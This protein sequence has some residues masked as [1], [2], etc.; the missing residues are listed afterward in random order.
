[1]AF[2]RDTFVIQDEYYQRSMIE[3]ISEN[4][5]LFNQGTNNALILDVGGITGDY[6]YETFFPDDASYDDRR[7]ETNVSDYSFKD[8]TQSEEVTVDIARVNGYKKTLSSWYKIAQTPEMLSTIAG[9]YMAR[10]RTRSF[11]RDSLTS[12]DASM[13]SIGSGVILDVTGETTKTMKAE[14]INEACGKFGDMASNLGV[15]I[16]HS[17]IYRDMIGSYITDNIFNIT[18]L[19][20]RA[21]FVPALGRT[22]VVTDNEALY[23]AIGAW[24]SEGTYSIGDK[25]L[26]GTAV[27][28][29]KTGTNTSTS[30]ASDSTNWEAS[31]REYYSYLLSSGAGK[32]SQGKMD[33]IFTDVNIASTN[34]L[35]LIKAEYNANI[36]VKGMSW[37]VSGGGANP[38]LAALGTST[39]WTQVATSI[40]NTAGVKITSY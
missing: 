40:K 17:K 19:A 5:N 1:M 2:T 10:S 22:V 11:L 16:V 38:T 39:N 3:N 7:D 8:I 31:S 28:V 34:S 30:P 36:K 15:M 6:K 25:V 32:I 4:I 24:V 27:Y 14:Y 21:E 33:S 35:G 9:V 29:N 26:V 18:D 20:L 12:I 13:R 37:N 23:E